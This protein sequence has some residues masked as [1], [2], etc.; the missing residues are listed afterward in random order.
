VQ[1][2]NPGVFSA[3]VEMR[4][5]F[6]PMFLTLTGL[7]ASAAWSTSGAQAPPACSLMTNA[8][9]EK[10]TGRRLYSDSE[11]TS[12][13]G[14]AGSACT[15]GAGGAQIVLFSGPKSQELWN[16]FLKN[17]G[18]EKEAKHPVPAAG[19]GAYIMYPKPRDEYEDTVGVLV[20]KA[21]PHTLGIS[22]A[23]AE[24][25]P[26]ESVQPRLVTLAKAVVA[27]LR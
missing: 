10:I 25:E 23:A 6:R 19:D 3:E 27:K 12:L 2:R 8:E 14:G 21:G 1:Q 13:A 17:F 26:A 7:L 15:Y 22:L 11:P 9:I 18:K 20:V 16:N 4:A 24:G 5:T